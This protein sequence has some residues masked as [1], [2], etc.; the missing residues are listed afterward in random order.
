MASD[1][2]GASTLINLQNNTQKHGE[3]DAALLGSVWLPYKTTDQKANKNPKTAMKQGLQGM[4]AIPVAKAHRLKIQ[5]LAK[6]DHFEQLAHL[7][8][9]SQF[10]C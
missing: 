2:L 5:A 4:A 9:C 3:T 8:F 1:I 7:M 6:A 10:G